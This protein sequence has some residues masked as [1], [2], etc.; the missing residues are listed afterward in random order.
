MAPG[1][2]PKEGKKRES[3]VI[4]QKDA[5][6]EHRKD[7]VCDPDY[8]PEL[9][10]TIDED[11]CA[12]NNA[13]EACVR[14]KRQA[15]MAPGGVRTR[16]KTALAVPPVSAVLTRGRKSLTKCQVPSADRHTH[17]LHAG[18]GLEEQNIHVS[19]KG[20]GI[21]QGHGGNQVGSGGGWDGIDQGH[22]GNT[23]GSGGDGDGIAQGHGDNQ[24]ASGGDG[25]GLAQTHGD[26]QVASGGDGDGLAQTHGDNMMASEDDDPQEVPWIRGNNK[27][28]A[29]QRMS[30]FRRG[31]LPVV[32]RKGD[33]R[34]LQAAVAAKF[35]TEYNIT[36]RNHVPVF[37]KWKDYKHQTAIHKMFRMKI[38]KKFDIN[39]DDADV[40]FACVQMMKKA[41]RQHRYHL[42]MYFN[43]YQLYLVRKTSLKSMTD[44][45]WS[46]LVK[47]WPSEK[48]LIVTIIHGDK[49]KEQEADAMDMYKEFHCSKK[50]GFTPDVQLAIL[51][52]HAEDEEAPSATE[53]VV[54]VLAEKTKKPTFLQNVG[55]Q[56]KKKGT[57][58]EQLAAEKLAKDEPTSQMEELAKKLQESEQARVAEQQEMARQQAETNAKLDLLLS[59]IGHT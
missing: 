25:D 37:P 44:T 2:G 18:D 30:R 47:S 35:A 59:Q 19:S 52:G 8:L 45:Q 16:K 11:L 20:D 48:M 50:K 29:L 6:P 32:I 56:S 10:E 42:K 26:N 33:I 57:L 41:V 43:P 21:A 31:K 38:A 7:G 1:S 5:T 28:A 9:D 24:V 15:C 55:I 51:S 54:A 27:G 53:V 34:P 14:N 4:P 49:Y 17:P 46:E 22:R 12:A 40:R 36:V 58:K 23:V 39:I 13:K 3:L